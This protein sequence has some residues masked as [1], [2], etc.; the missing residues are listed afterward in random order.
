VPLVS[1]GQIKLSDIR[2]EY[3]LG[4]G[5]IAMSSL[6]GKGNAAASGQIQMAA[7]FYGTSNITYLADGTLT[8]GRVL[9][10]SSRYYY[11]RH[12]NTPNSNSNIGSFSLST[13]TIGLNRAYQDPLNDNLLTTGS[14]VATFRVTGDRIDIDTVKLGSTTRRRRYG[15][16]N[17]L[18]F[19]S[20]KQITATLPVMTN[21]TTYDVEIVKLADDDPFCT[22]TFQVSSWTT[23]T[24]KGETLYHRGFNLSSS[25][26]NSFGNRG[27]VTSGT[28]SV[29]N[30]ENN[31][32]YT[33]I[34]SV[35]ATNSTAQSVGGGY[36]GRIEVTNNTADGLKDRM[37]FFVL[38][39]N[40]DNKTYVY[41]INNLG[42]SDFEPSGANTYRTI[43]S[44][45]AALLL[46]E[47][48]NVFYNFLNSTSATYT[49]KIV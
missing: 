34:V 37:R 28:N 23:T 39:R 7:N 18:E 16:L 49:L 3:A 27:S 42:T 25:T 44:G 32:S 4:S 13:N 47:S 38:S 10:K 31:S 43:A 9:D 5:Q 46:N 22:M 33:T 19:N 45:N 21:G 1:S 29:K 48:N 24:G 2:N 20:D 12:E 14:Q 11:G 26:Q 15:E 36:S 8:A 40:N 6:Y 35:M 30:P 41:R 17:F